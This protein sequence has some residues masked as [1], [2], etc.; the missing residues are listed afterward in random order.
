[1]QSSPAK[2][3]AGVPS[4]MD[5]NIT[6]GEDLLRAG[7]TVDVMIAKNDTIRHWAAIVKQKNQSMIRC[8]C[9]SND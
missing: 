7:A 8:S 2:R 5:V 9:A 3:I 6:D 4:R 1:M